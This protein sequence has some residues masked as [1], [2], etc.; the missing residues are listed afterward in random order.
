MHTEH[1]TYFPHALVWDV[2]PPAAQTHTRIA[3][4]LICIADPQRHKVLC[5]PEEIE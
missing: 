5:Q 2:S 4:L 1:S 3:A